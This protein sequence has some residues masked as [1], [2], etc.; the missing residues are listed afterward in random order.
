[1]K[2]NL[3]LTSMLLLLANCAPGGKLLIENDGLF[4]DNQR[5]VTSSSVDKY[6]ETFRHFFLENGL[7][8]LAIQNSASPMVCLNMTIRVG[9]AFEDYHSSGMSHMLEHLLF[10]GTSKRT[11]EELYRDNDFYGIYSNAFTRKL[12]TDFFILFPSQ[13]LPEGMDI[14][15]DMIFNSILPPDKLEKERGIVIE[16][17]R[18]DRDSESYEVQ[19]Y[20]D[21]VNFGSSGVGL[22]TLGTIST[23]ENMPR[24]E[25]Y[26]FYKTHYVPNNM[27]L[28]VIGKFDFEDLKSS[29]EEYYGTAPPKPL[30]VDDPFQ[31]EKNKNPQFFVNQTVLPV[32]MVKGQLVYQLPDFE[33]TSSADALVA[34]KTRLEVYSEFI[35]EELSNRMSAYNP[36]ISVADY[37]GNE[38]LL[39]DFTANPDDDINAVIGEI[40]G[41]L[42]E[43]QND[44]EKIVTGQKLEYW[45]KQK[46][47]ANIS[48]L[49][50]PHY[51]SMMQSGDLA[52]GGDYTIAKMA[53]LKKVKASEI[54]NSFAQ[55]LNAPANINLVRPESLGVQ[56]TTLQETVYAKSVLPS[57]ATLITA[58]SGGSRMFGMH[59]L[60]KN[61]STIEGDLTGGAEILHSLLESGTDQYTG[62]E[63]KDQLAAI[64]AQTKYIDMSFIPYDDY[65]N[66]PEWGYIRFECLEEDAESGIRLLTHMLGHTVLT[67]SKVK[68]GIADAGRRQMMQQ[69]S[70][71][72]TVVTEFRK[73]FFGENDP[74]TK[75]VSGDSE[76]LAKINLETLTDLQKRYFRPENYIVSISS[77]ISHEKLKEIFN[78]VWTQKAEPVPPVKNEINLSA[79]YQEKILD[80]GKDQAQIRLGYKFKIADEDKALFSLMTNILS[81]KMMFDLRETR[82]LA[83]TLGMSA[84]F[85]SD[86]GWL[87]ASMGTGGDNIDE[88]LSG[89]KS[90]FDPARLDRLTGDEVRKTVNSNKGRF[91]M[92]NLK[93][94]GQAFYMG[95]YEFLTGDYQNAVKRNY[96]FDETTPEEIQ[97]VAEKYLHLPENYTV[98]IVK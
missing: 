81:D 6:P 43:I 56:D 36:G 14:Q 73:L 27:I 2:K 93:R 42:V 96:Q 20:F 28:T 22:P 89:M 19:N 75:S 9:S 23:I 63:I 67:E 88:A 54:I 39:V 74:S 82:G 46:E 49:D 60:V 13:Y 97:A 61:R 26:D 91:M 4:P 59:I 24:D 95:Y 38:K 70:A 1:M 11:Q 31:W 57:G 40:A 7:E 30:P 86:T 94:I 98:V 71:R 72:K 21:R 15:S 18:K 45:V 85:Q 35:S 44:L 33:S 8:V 29:L 90:Y 65:Y 12:Y 34:A 50:S 47:V 69:S 17:I 25:I 92:R 78:S 3:L 5:Q 41:S 55:V 77:G 64:G 83:Y 10:N 84:G 68:K 58:T 87:I 52:L 66:S 53:E 16:E 80:L 48:L 76:S 62:E 32:K 37:P 79:P 51:Y